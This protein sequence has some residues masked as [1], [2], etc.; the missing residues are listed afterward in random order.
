MEG[1]MDRKKFD[2]LNLKSQVEYINKRLS[3]GES[4]R[5]ICDN[6][7]IQRKTIRIRFKKINYEFSKEENKYIFNTKVLQDQKEDNN[8]EEYKCN[9]MVIQNESDNK[10]DLQIKDIEYKDNISVL[11]DK[12]ENYNNTIVLKDNI[13]E[14]LFKIIEAKEELFKIIDWFKKQQFEDNLIEVPELRIDREKF[15]GEIK[16]TT[17][18]VYSEIK[19]RFQEFIRKFPEYKSQDMY[20]QALLEFMIKYEKL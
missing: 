1:K 12:T 9:T 19:D 4:L 16:I 17:I 20:T 10:I 13:K 5:K 3:F 8:K 6:I 11:D 14:D 7:G 2:R 15:K 18:R